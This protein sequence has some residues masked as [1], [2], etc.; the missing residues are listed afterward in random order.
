VQP[1]NHTHLVC[2]AQL[3]LAQSAPLLDPAKHLLDAAARV[4]RFG[5]APVARGTPIDGGTTG[6]GGVLRDVRRHAD[7]PHLGDKTSRVLIV[8]C[9]QGFLVGTG[10]ARQQRF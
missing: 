2:A 1:K 4:D 5:V 7:A 9:T 10:L 8:V 6:A 3:E